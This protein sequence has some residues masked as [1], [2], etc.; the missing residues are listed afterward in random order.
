[1]QSCAAEAEPSRPPEFGEGRA[2][3]LRALVIGVVCILGVVLFIHYAELVLGG[4]RGHT[5]LANTSIPVG[6]FFALFVLTVG[7]LLLRRLRRASALGR[8]ELLV[9]YIMMTS[10]TVMAS[11]G[12]IHFLV[13]TLAAPFHF[14]TPEND[15]E[16]FHPYIP[17]WFAPQSERVLKG[18]YDGDATV[19][20]HAWLVPIAAWTA[21]MLLVAGT[22]LC[23]CA[24]AREQWIEHEKL[25]FP[26]VY[27]PLEMTKAGSAFWKSKPMWIAF[28]IAFTIGTVNTL[29]EN[30]PAIPQIRV[31]PYDISPFIKDR[32]WSAIG[33]TPVAFYPFVIGIAYLLSTEVT[34][35]C[36]FFYLLTKMQAIFGAVTGLE[37][38][39]GGTQS[40]SFPFLM[41]QGAGAFVA[42]VLIS[43]WLGRGHLKRVILKAAGIDRRDGRVQTWPL[44]G[45]MAGLG[46][47]VMFARSAGMSLVAPLVLFGLSFVYMTA[48]TRIRAETGNAWLFGPT[49][50][51]HTLMTRTFGPRIFSPK[52]L[53]IMA[54]LRNISSYDLRCLA[55]PHQL[56]GFKMAREAGLDVKRLSAT[57]LSAAAVALPAAFL[58][59]LFIWYRFGALGECDTWRTL[60]GRKPFDALA[61][62]LTNP[63]PPDGLGTGFVAGGLVVMVALYTLRM[64]LS[65]WPLHPVG[66]AMANT[67]TMAPLWMP[68]FIAWAAKS[69]ILRYG[70]AGLYRRSMP[71]FL[72]LIAGDFFNGAL[73]TLVGCFVNMH[74]YPVNW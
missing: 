70:G 30:F 1:M 63:L 73:W 2:F 6:P 49:V 65:W 59:G 9:I 47:L 51:P 41:H 64:H 7:N 43:V 52:D 19:P 56:D 31:R 44:W 45:L 17:T 46:G 66:Y 39:G 13:P 4:R 24:L 38:L 32:P 55:M 54:Y 10:S 69:V 26:T 3:T 22:T 37:R 25:T 53:T 35:S 15:W 34:F 72:G 42:I 8:R 68:F 62:E 16:Q 36:W 12:G 58:I 48:A 29:S 40:E 61:A 28:G 60:M 33:Y 11:S 5:A 74:V 20:L 71:F 18:F 14:A 21:F 23:I 67:Q 50:D 27:V 57:M